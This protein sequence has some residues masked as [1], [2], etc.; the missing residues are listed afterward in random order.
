VFNVVLKPLGYPTLGWALFMDLS[1][2][3]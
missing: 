3:N 2:N 1:S